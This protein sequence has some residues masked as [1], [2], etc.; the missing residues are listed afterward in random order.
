MGVLTPIAGPD[1]ARETVEYSV[2]EYPDSTITVLHVLPPD[3]VVSAGM[4]GMSVQ[5]SNTE[6][7]AE[8][9]DELFATAS[10]TAD[11]LGGSVSTRTAVG[12]PVR[13]IVGIAEES[14]TDHIVMGN[15][16]RSGLVRLLYGNVT[17]GVVRRAAVPVTVVR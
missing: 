5:G 16:S 6:R 15:C 17:A 13:Q 1:S 10:E 14:A 3:R 12:R 11:S 2:R 4:Y 7:Q 9:V 8:N